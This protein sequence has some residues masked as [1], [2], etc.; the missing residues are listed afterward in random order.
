MGSEVGER[1][2]GSVLGVVVRTARRSAGLT[3][4]DLGLG[5]ATRLYERIFRGGSVQIL[6]L[7]PKEAQVEVVNNRLFALGYFRN[8]F[9]GLV[10]GG[11][12]LFCEKVYVHELPKLTNET[13]IGL[14]ISWA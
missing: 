12:Q 3:P 9:R 10:I 7:G 11:L 6:K 1:V 14:R 5:H 13:A 8:A 2:Q 4:S